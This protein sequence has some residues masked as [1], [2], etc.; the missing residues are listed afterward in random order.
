MAHPDLS[1]EKERLPNIEILVNQDLL[2]LKGVG[3]DVSPTLLQGHVVVNLAES[4]SIKEITLQFRGKARLPPPANEPLSSGPMT[5]LVCS[6]DWSFLEG[7]KKHQHT[8]KAGRHVFPF[9]LNIGGSL[10]SS[11]TTSVFGGASIAYKLRAVATRPGFAHNLQA[12]IPIYI[13]R[14]FAPEALEYQQTLE[15]ENTWPEKIMY[16]IMIPH[17]AWAAGDTLT[18]VV[19]FSPLTKG[20]RVLHVTTTINET[21]K[22]YTRT[23]WQENTRPAVTTKHDIVNGRA[24]LVE[25]SLHRPKVPHHH[26][27][28]HPHARASQPPTPGTSTPALSSGQYSPVSGPSSARSSGYFPPVHPTGSEHNVADAHL[29]MTSHA[30]EAGPSSS[31][32][33]SEEGSHPVSAVPLPG[34]FQMA[35]TDVV[36]TL[37]VPIPMS[38]TPTHSLEPIMINHRIRWSILI[39]NLDGHTS[40]LRCSLP[41]HILDHRLIDEARSATAQ[42]RR[43]LLGGPEIEQHDEDLEL[44]SYSSHVRDR[45]ANMYLPEQSVM[46]VTNPWVHQGVS[47]VQG[48]EGYTS[49]GV[50]T[51][52]EAHHV[53]STIPGQTYATNLEYVN[54]ELLLSLSHEHPPPLQRT[55]STRTDLARVDSAPS[56]LDS[57]SPSQPDSQPVSHPS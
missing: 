54:S 16:S 51:P 4:T 23:G 8:L 41:L 26:T 30:P 1:H 11:I 56:P 27:S 46:R 14:S 9:Q 39:S 7:D 45:V 37:D 50:H 24:V 15:I 3:V 42:T 17:K 18:A 32:H 19:K 35:D 44:P 29:A 22:L 38:C 57:G 5:Y 40:E 10:P 21:V 34:D 13:A 33:T 48:H 36:S 49:T 20:V 47:P 53:P 31:S 28:Y 2:L 12:Q 52:L 43:L 25:D 55:D 6:H